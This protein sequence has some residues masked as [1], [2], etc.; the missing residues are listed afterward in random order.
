MELARVKL[1]VLHYVVEIVKYL[2]FAA[3]GKTTW[4]NNPQILITINLSLR[5]LLHQLLKQLFTDL[6]DR[7]PQFGHLLLL[8]Q[9]LVFFE[10]WETA[11]CLAKPIFLVDKPK[12]GRCH[13]LLALEHESP[14]LD[15]QTSRE[16]V[17]VSVPFLLV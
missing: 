16:A 7:S 9:L 2:D 1:N 6:H 17:Q 4:L 8:R 15:R 11:L 14:L 12:V 3:A 10:L 5:V 13:L